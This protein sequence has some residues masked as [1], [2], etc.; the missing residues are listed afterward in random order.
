M[1][2]WFNKI[3]TIDDAIDSLQR[4]F[5]DMEINPKI[6]EKLYEANRNL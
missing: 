3:Q 5:G 2:E 1:C 6:L 4:Y